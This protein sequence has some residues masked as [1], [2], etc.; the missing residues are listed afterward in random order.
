[1]T[2]K[3]WDDID[4]GGLTMEGSD[5][6]STTAEEQ[7]RQERIDVEKLKKV[8]LDQGDVFPV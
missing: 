6:E 3:S 4:L 1:M 2:Q 8:V 7:A 5:D